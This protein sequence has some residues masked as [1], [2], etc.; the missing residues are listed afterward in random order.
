MNCP[1]CGAPIQNSANFCER[2]GNPLHR[3]AEV[4]SYATETRGGARPR[5]TSA[6]DPYKDQIKQMK[7]QLKQV[8]LYLRQVTTQMSSTRARYHE[9]AAF[10]PF[11]ILSKGYKWFE[12]IRLLGPQ[13]QKEQLQRQILQMEQEL[14]GLQQAQEEWKQQR[15]L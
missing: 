3:V 7:L 4:N 12:D 11:G 10:V 8:R 5:G 9:T 14:L 15:G 1:A 2:C 6:Q 13:Q